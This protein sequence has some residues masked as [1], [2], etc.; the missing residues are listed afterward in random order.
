MDIQRILLLAGLAITSY[1]LILKWNEDYGANG[2]LVEENLEPVTEI[3]EPS[4]VDTA[5]LSL[6][7]I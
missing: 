3:Y 1:M 7:H 6:I 4:Q 5:D 2:K